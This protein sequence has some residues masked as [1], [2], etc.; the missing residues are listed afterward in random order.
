MDK[1]RSRTGSDT[2]RLPDTDPVLRRELIHHL[3][4]FLT[5]QR[6]EKMAAVL[7]NRTRYITVV[8]EDIYQP[9]NASAVLRS[10]D[11]F[12]VQD[13]YIIENRNT[14]EINPGVELGTSSWLSLHTFNQGSYNTPE[15]VGYLRDRGYRI[16]ATSPH[17]NGTALEDFDLFKGKTAV[18]FGNELEGLS[19]EL[20]EDADEHIRI[21]MYGFVESFNISVSC[22]LTL[23]H[24][25]YKLRGLPLDW[26]LSREE[27]EEIMLHWLRGSIKRWRT[28]E[29]EWKKNRL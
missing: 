16:A 4:G 8:L 17:T 25:T 19:E 13:A 21:P 7:E 18:F 6:Y 1:D 5:K 9:H 28:I 26:R 11:G 20:L 27:K 24:L 22:A 29:E 10:C 2:G 12:G 15:T 23:H 3:S 14:Y